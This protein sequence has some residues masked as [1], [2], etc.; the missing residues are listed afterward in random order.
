M[1]RMSD[2]TRVYFDHAATTPLEPLVLE[3][4]LPLLR[5]EYGNPSSIY[6]TGRSVAG[7]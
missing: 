1:E 7:A 3:A 2:V 4:M 6:R 5:G